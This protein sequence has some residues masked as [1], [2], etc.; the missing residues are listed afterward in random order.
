CRVELDHDVAERGVVALARLERGVFLLAPI[1]IL[2]ANGSMYR[3]SISGTAGHRKHAIRVLTGPAA[4]ARRRSV[5]YGPATITALRAIWTAAGYPWSLRLNG[6]GTRETVRIPARTREA[7]HPC[8]WADAAS[9]RAL[10]SSTP[11]INMSSLMDAS[12]PRTF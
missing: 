5:S 12:T 3:R 11:V 4:P 10:V 1:G 9:H 7:V 6:L 8:E 2:R